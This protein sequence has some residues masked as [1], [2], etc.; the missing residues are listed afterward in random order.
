MK[1]SLTRRQFLKL[2][3]TGL[4]IAVASTSTGIRL[5]SAAEVKKEGQSFRP[6]AWIEVR[7]D[8]IVVV[9]VNKSEMGQGIYTSLPMI[10]A[11]ELDADWKNVRMEVAPADDA[12]KD[13]VWGSQSTGGSSSIRH[14]HDPLRKA[15]AAARAMLLTAAARE[16]GVSVKECASDI[17]KVRHIKSNRTIAYGNLTVEAAKLEIPQDPVLKKEGQF[18]Y[19][20][21][22]MPRLDTV[23]KV[24]GRAGFGIDSFV[25]GMVYAAIARPPDILADLASHDAAAAQ[26]IAGV[27]AVLPIH[28]GMAVCADTIDAAWKGRDALK[29]KWQNG[30]Y[31]GLSNASLERDF[32]SRLDTAGIVARNDGDAAGTIERAARKFEAVYQLPFLSHATMEPMNCTAHVRSDGCD[33]WV[34]T[35]NQTGARATAVKATGLKPEQ[36]KIHTTFLG[37]G[38]GRRFEQ[39]FVEEAVL[40]SMST[41]RPVKLV[42]KREEDMQ[43]DFYRPMNASRIRASLDADGRVSAWS[44][45]IVCPSIFARVFPGSMKK[46]IDNAAVEGLENMEYEIPNVNVEYVRFDTPI[47]VGFWRSVGSSHNAFTVES[48]VDELAHAARKDP[49][50]FR[51]ALLKKHPR[52]RRV[53]EVAAEKAGWGKPIEKGHARGIAYHL[54]FGSYVAEVAEVSVESA[55]GVVKVHK[56]TC[57]VD[58]GSVVNPDTVKAQMM[59]CIVMGLSAALKEQIEISEG[60]IRSANFSDYQ[61]LRMSETPDIDVHIVKS[62]EAL[63]GIGEPGVPPAA[64][65][66]ANAV[67]AAT[68]ARIRRLPMK[69]ETVLAAMNQQ[70]K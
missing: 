1:T 66:V 45:K 48:F 57:A 9:T 16:W 41:G 54:S 37:G 5:L 36:V 6:N 23:D 3:G 33:I 62:G 60:G 46:G 13:P 58:C 69:P 8:N 43:K 11:D 59:G 64:P 2:S 34:P 61:I 31:P 44:H 10:V 21:K 56:V 65:A 67:F 25:P 29:A 32:L 42:W 27:R 50:E 55:T 52:A 19:I 24:N 15:G 53:L 63:G 39:D 7:A 14:M 18:R 20:G 4:A 28:S 30:K 68:G 12:Y 38:F 51:L 26:A 49:L 47:P 22:D 35:Q 17:G 70:K 40:L